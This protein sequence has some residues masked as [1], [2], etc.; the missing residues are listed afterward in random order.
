MREGVLPFSNS[1]TAL[2]RRK[3][4]SSAASSWGGAPP[5]AAP[6]VR[7]RETAAF[8]RE[9]FEARGYVPGFAGPTGTATSGME[10]FLAGFLADFGTA[11]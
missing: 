11:K 1:T 7:G 6:E 8:P 2:A 9:P 3:A 5:L 4:S 10:D